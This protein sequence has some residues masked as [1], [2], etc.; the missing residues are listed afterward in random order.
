MVGVD[1]RLVYGSLMV[2]KVCWACQYSRGIYV[3]CDPLLEGLLYLDM[4]STAFTVNVSSV[5]NY[6][7]ESSSVYSAIHYLVTLF[8]QMKV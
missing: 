1:Q 5:G 7:E 2:A 6:L 8:R 3:C 4:Y